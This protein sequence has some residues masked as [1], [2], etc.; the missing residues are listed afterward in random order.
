MGRGGGGGGGPGNRGNQDWMEVSYNVPAAKCGIIIGKGGETIKSINQMTGAHVELSRNQPPNPAE[1]C[2]VIRG[3]PNQ[4]DHA[5]Q[6]INEKIGGNMSASSGTPPVS[7]YG[8][9]AGSSQQPQGGPG[10]PMGGQQAP[11]SG[12][13]APQ[14]WNTAYQQ[15]WSSQ[16]VAPGGNEMNKQAQD[17]NAAAW[18]AYY[19]QYYGQV[20][21]GAQQPIAG[22][23]G[24][25][26]QPTAAGQ[27]A[28]ASQ[29]AAAGQPDYSAAWVEY[30]RS[31]GMYREADMVEQQARTQQNQAQAPAAQPG[32]AA[33]APAATPQAQ[34]PVQAAPNQP[35][36]SQPQA[37]YSQYG[38]YGQYGQQPAGYPY[39]YPAYQQPQ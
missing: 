36:N 20:Q 7:N 3:L 10:Y 6:L 22:P 19:A 1:K 16:P 37:Q 4:I 32:S 34:A 23:P 31:L 28:G 5:K 35:S 8:I 38:Q 25:Q 2:F 24:A 15:P 39:N 26:T 33:P 14:G 11:P 18:A 12:G 29:V 27:P 13:Y 21:P 9:P 30:Y 17:A